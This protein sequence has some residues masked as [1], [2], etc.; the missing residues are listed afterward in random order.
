[1]DLSVHQLRS[2]EGVNDNGASDFVILGT[3]LKLKNLDE[4]PIKSVMNRI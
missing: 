3:R 4:A 2:I 1:M